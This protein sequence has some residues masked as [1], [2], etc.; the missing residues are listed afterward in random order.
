MKKHF[1]FGDQ[2][3]TLVKYYSIE[4]SYTIRSLSLSARRP[5]AAIIQVQV[6]VLSV[7]TT[8]QNGR[9]GIEWE[10]CA[11][12][13]WTAA[14]KLCS[15]MISFCCC[16]G[17]NASVQLHNRYGEYNF[18]WIIYMYFHSHY[19]INYTV[20]ERAFATMHANLHSGLQKNSCSDK[21]VCYQYIVCRRNFLPPLIDWTHP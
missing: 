14:V 21:S 3:R 2:I 16:C 18:R 11:S 7:W 1:L 4:N 20:Q 5:S 10:R 8:F 15:S 19:N 9:N 13:K 6:K 17:H 12:I